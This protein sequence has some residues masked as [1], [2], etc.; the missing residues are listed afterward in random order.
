M[1]LNAS[2]Q[3]HIDFRPPPRISLADW[4]VKT[5]M[6][7]DV[8]GRRQCL[9]TRDSFFLFNFVIRKL[10][11]GTK[12]LNLLYWNEGIFGVNHVS[13]SAFK[14]VDLF[15][16]FAFTV[17]SFIH[18]KKRHRTI[19]ISDLFI[20]IINARAGIYRNLLFFGFFNLF[21]VFTPDWGFFFL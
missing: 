14:P 15:C 13:I 19:F 20:I 3:S 17:R 18:K 6:A 1:A 21:R 5:T 2:Q 10:F 8:A 16:F 4:L 11:S 12:C 9:F 7:C